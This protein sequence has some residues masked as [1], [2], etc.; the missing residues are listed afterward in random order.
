[1]SDSER[2]QYL[3]KKHWKLVKRY[4]ASR[5][6]LL[7][8]CFKWVSHYKFLFDRARVDLRSEFAVNPDYRVG[9][10]REK[11]NLIFKVNKYK[12]LY[13]RQLKT[14]NWLLNYFFTDSMLNI[15]LKPIE[16][17]S[18]ESERIKMVCKN[19]DKEYYTYKKKLL[20]DSDRYELCPVCRNKK[21]CTICC[22]LHYNKGSTCSNKCMTELTR[23][24]RR[25]NG[26]NNFMKRTAENLLDEEF[27][28]YQELEEEFENQDNF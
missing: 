27:F 5:D 28:I 16:N 10:I 3:L 6:V 24:K 26:F 21:F 9:S 8:S 17:I 18:F 25:Y 20:F 4:R 23:I 19:C 7:K 14:Y 11:Y 1:M 12:N 13:F 22:S 15:N 2:K